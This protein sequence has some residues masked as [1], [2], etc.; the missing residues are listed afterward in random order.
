MANDLSCAVIKKPTGLWSSYDF[1]TNSA[2]E[3]DLGATLSGAL[4]SAVAANVQIGYRCSVI[5][6]SA[7]DLAVAPPGNSY[8]AITLPAGDSS[9]FAYSDDMIFLATDAGLYHLSSTYA[10]SWV[11]ATTLT[12]D[13]LSGPN[14]KVFSYRIAPDSD[15]FNV[16]IVTSSGTNCKYHALRININAVSPTYKLVAKGD[17]TTQML[18][19]DIP[20]VARS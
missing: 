12:S 10:A 20:S 6:I 14:K 5:K 3:T 9:T 13:L 15:E 2:V 8:N 18:S 19:G 7:S 17:I 1:S 11:S 16:L 4:D